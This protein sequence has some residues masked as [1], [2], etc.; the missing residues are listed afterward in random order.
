VNGIYFL[1]YL[2]GTGASAFLLYS[3]KKAWLTSQVKFKIVIGLVSV[4]ILADIFINNQNI[5]TAVN[6][7]LVPPVYFII[8][9]FFKLI[10]LRINNRDFKLWLKGSD[11]V[12]Q[13]GFTIRNDHEFEISDKLFSLALLVIISLLSAFALRL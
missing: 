4:K 5:R 10:S 3:R 13:D 1:G 6:C 7:L 2:T 12:I 8:D 9:Y 11:E